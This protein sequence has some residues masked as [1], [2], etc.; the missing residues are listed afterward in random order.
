MTL[1]I[2]LAD[3]FERQLEQEAHRFGLSVEQYS[4]QVLVRHLEEARKRQAAVDLLESWLSGD[5]AEQKATG[6]ELVRALDKDRLSSRS[7]FPSELQGVTW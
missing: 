1:T 5:A 6:E 3:K 4:A 7:L 2:T